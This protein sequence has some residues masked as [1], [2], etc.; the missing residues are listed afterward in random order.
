MKT[1]MGLCGFV[2]SMYEYSMLSRDI[3]LNAKNK[4][5]LYY[6]VKYISNMLCYT[7]L[8]MLKWM[9]KGKYR[10]GILRTRGNVV[11]PCRLTSTEE[12]LK[13]YIFIA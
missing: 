4:V 3:L 9:R 6:Y 7:M 13:D 8:Y 1:S 10:I 5:W 12:T 11:Q 2:L